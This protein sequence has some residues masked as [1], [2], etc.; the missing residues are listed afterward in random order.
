M[1]SSR[2]EKVLERNKKHVVL[3][4]LMAAVL[5]VGLSSTAL[6]VSGYVSKLSP[7]APEPVR[8][9]STAELPPLGPIAIQ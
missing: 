6:A 2:L 8:V 9:A 3:D 4:L 1:K 7:N 5:L